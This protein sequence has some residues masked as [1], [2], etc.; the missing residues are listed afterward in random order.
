VPN[1][2]DISVY[3][4]LTWDKSTRQTGDPQTQKVYG[5]QVEDP[6]GRI[7]RDVNPVYGTRT[8]KFVTLDSAAIVAGQL[9]TT[10]KYSLTYY[11][12]DTD[13]K[14]TNDYDAATTSQNR[15]AGVTPCLRT[16]GNVGWIQTT[17]KT[18]VLADGSTFAAGLL[19]YPGGADGEVTAQGSLGTL[20]SNY[21]PIG[22]ALGASSGSPLTV[23][24]QLAI[25]E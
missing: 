5:A 13:T 23:L 24:V 17:G 8:F 9:T 14:V 16:P 7:Y 4:P 10:A 18:Y 3:C 15:P 21:E 20:G 11:C 22:V 12:N 6:L 19:V 2:S 25:G 1:D